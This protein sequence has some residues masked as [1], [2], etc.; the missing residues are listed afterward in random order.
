MFMAMRDLDHETLVAIECLL[1]MLLFFIWDSQLVL[2]GSGCKSSD[3]CNAIVLICS[4]VCVANYMYEYGCRCM[5]H[6]YL[7]SVHGCVRVPLVSCFIEN[8]TYEMLFK[9]KLDELLLVYEN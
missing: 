9:C 3:L 1:W 4:I 8:M 7:F 6:L 2:Q 5:S